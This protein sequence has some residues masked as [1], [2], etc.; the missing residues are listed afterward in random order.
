MTLQVYGSA[1]PSRTG[2]TRAVRV[3]EV[4]TTYLLKRETDRDGSY[5]ETGGDG[6]DCELGIRYR[7]ED[8][9]KEWGPGPSISPARTRCDGGTWAYIF[10]TDTDGEV[11]PTR[12]SSVPG[13][14][15]TQGRGSCRTLLLTYLQ[16][17]LLA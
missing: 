5:E 13:P 10:V 8:P 14:D 4:R 16:P 11:T 17:Y 3:Q 2:D 7:R 6:T 1:P 12:R 15:P 9:S